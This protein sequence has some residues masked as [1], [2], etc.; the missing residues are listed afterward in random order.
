MTSA[1][2]SNQTSLLQALGRAF[3][4]AV[5]VSANENHART[6]K[7]CLRQFR[8]IEVEGFRSGVKALRR[9][10][11][12]LDNEPFDLV[13]VDEDLGDMR[14]LDLVRLARLHPRLQDLPV[15]V[16]SLDNTRRAVLDAVGAGASGYL[17][18]PYSLQAL[19]G[20]LK[21]SVELIGFRREQRQALDEGRNALSEKRFED[22]IERFSR[23]VATAE[24][25]PEEAERLY[26]DGMIHLARKRYGAAI[27][28]FHRAIRI[29]TLYAEAYEGLALAWKGKGHPANYKKYMAMA[30]QVYA[31]IER[32]QDAK[33]V[34]VRLQQADPEAQ[35]PYLALGMAMVKRDNPKDAARFYEQA[36]RLGA[37]DH[38]VY[39]HIARACHFTEQPERAAFDVCKAMAATGR[40]PKA[41]ATFERVMGPGRLGRAQAGVMDRPR[42]H[43]PGGERSSKVRDM[44]AVAGYTVSSYIKGKAEP[45]SNDQLM[46]LDE[47][48]AGRDRRKGAA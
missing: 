39:H 22:A 28:S 11:E 1:T 48:E 7:A 17:I 19:A 9:V 36:M 34:F 13:I 3:H 33:K 16:A 30:A 10:I 2:R 26:R 5:V 21:R 38:E 20:Q 6:D 4:R 24:A 46:D 14:G 41:H 44:L 18:R 35:N 31:K 8:I 45:V 40:F 42:S 12:R 37:R 29:N 25:E 15:L 27:Q 43:H 47:A 32:F 23:V